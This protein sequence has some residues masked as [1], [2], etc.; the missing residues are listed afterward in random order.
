ITLTQNNNF[1]GAVSLANSG[2]NNVSLTNA[3]ATVLGA[4]G[5]GSGT[6][7]V[8]S[9]GA[10]TQAAGAGAASFSAGANAITLTQANHFTGAVSLSNS[11]ANSVSLTNAV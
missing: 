11:G 5:V 3:V 9:T 6:L 4:S 7:T 1:T 10:I 8:H 2:A